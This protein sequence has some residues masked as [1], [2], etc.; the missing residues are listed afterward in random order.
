M[1]GGISNLIC[2]LGVLHIQ[3]NQTGVVH[4]YLAKDLGM[5]PVKGL[6][7]HIQDFYPLPVI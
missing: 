1:G 3:I 4:D 5:D 2:E 6:A 7:F